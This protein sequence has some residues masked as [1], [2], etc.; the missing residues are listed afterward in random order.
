MPPSRMLDVSLLPGGVESTSFSRA[1]VRFPEDYSD[2]IV[3]PSKD[4][5][6]WNSATFGTSERKDHAVVSLSCLVLDYDGKHGAFTLDEVRAMWPWECVIHSTWNHTPE[7]PRLRVILPLSREV[8]PAEYAALYAA[9]LARDPRLDPSCR[10]PSRFFYWPSKKSLDAPTVYEYKS[11]EPLDPAGLAATPRGGAGSSGPPFTSSK[12]P[13][14]VLRESAK[15]HGTEQEAPG[16]AADGRRVLLSLPL[17]S[18]AASNRGPLREDKPEVSP[19]TQPRAD[20]PFAGTAA[21]A[22]RKEDFA[23]ILTECPFAHHA[24]ADAA[25]LPNPEWRALLSILTRCE[26]GEA[27]AH[28]VSQP[29]A[30]YTEEETSREYERVAGFGPMTCATIERDAGVRWCGTCAH[31]GKITSPIQLGTPPESAAAPRTPP[32]IR[33]SKLAAANDSDDLRAAAVDEAIEKAE[34]RAAEARTA[35]GTAIARRDA[36]RR[37]YSLSSRIGAAP[38]ETDAALREKMDAEAQAREATAERRRC[39]L[40]LERLRTAQAVVGLPAGANPEVWSRLSLIAPGGVVKPAD[41][42]GNVLRV[43]NEDPA[44][45]D[46]LTFDTF[47]NA[48][49]FDGVRL[50]EGKDTEI[51]AE[52]AY[53]YTL[54]TTSAR[55]RECMYTSARR[56]EFHPVRQYL[57]ALEWDGK[58]RIDTMLF[59]GFGVMP[60]EYDDIVRL[61]SRRFLIS[62]IAR[63]YEPGC[64]V[65]TML[66]LHGAQGDGKSQ[67]FAALASRPWFGRTDLDMGNKDSYMQIEGTWLYELAELHA[68]RKAEAAKA[69]QWISSDTDRYRAPF[70]HAVADHPRQTVIVGSHNP[71][72]GGEFLTDATGNRRYWPAGVGRVIDVDWIVDHRDALFAE[73]RHLYMSERHLG[74]KRTAATRWWFAKGEAEFDRLAEMTE[75]H[76]VTDPWRYPIVMHLIAEAKRPTKNVVS[77]TAEDI[78]ARVFQRPNGEATHG[79]RTRIGRILSRIGLT[80]E[81][82]VLAG[83]RHTHYYLDAE[84]KIRLGVPVEMGAGAKEV[85]VANANPF[86]RS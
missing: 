13:P 78:L 77:F 83:S 65:D 72:E 73:A 62:M 76:M 86:E 26:E 70:A 58:H 85:Q 35:E 27:L 16:G 51:A 59:D 21:Q 79:E 34:A 22:E 67:A 5:G 68:L 7:A 40:A 52:L 23:R 53:R 50:S 28:V 75:R 30:G 1:Q 54:D 61:M 20:N 64:Q 3:S 6:L 57:D 84:S 29:Y 39:E 32:I 42:I 71:E 37:R 25:D 14:T 45:S 15:A 46:R 41:T 55:V 19:G 56:R 4:G 18:G 47:A 81:S 10:N 63:I 36:A 44:W 9:A 38:D 11:G 43:F 8:S 66:I 49:C 60:D 69:K 12:A 24:V 48:V 82:K 33:L 31:R 74:R 2:F 80:S 17:A